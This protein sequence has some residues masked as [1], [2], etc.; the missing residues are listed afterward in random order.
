MK[1]ILII[2][3]VLLLSFALVMMNNNRPKVIIGRLVKK[4]AGG[5]RLRYAVNLVG[6][7]PVGEAVFF[8]ERVEPYGAGEE[9]A[10]HLSAKAE[11]LKIYS[12]LVRGSALLDSYLDKTTLDPLL[13]RQRLL[14]S[15]EKEAQK[16]VFYDQGNRIMSIEGERR[17]I[18]S[19]T[20]DPLSALFNIRRMD[21][22][23]TKEFEMNINTN[24]KNYLLKAVA[25]IEELSIKNKKY[26]IVVIDADIS[27]RQKSPY[28]K[29]TMRLVLWKDRQNL[30]VYI[31]VFASGFLI[32]CRLIDIE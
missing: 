27:R 6:V 3:V 23:K 4:S 24:Q 21:F 1:K 2:L 22:D 12:R 11:S 9:E 26:R 10:Y 20:Q 16:E 15:G 18:L 25:R 17:E 31:K 32:S 14:F 8:K 7:I 30:P 19:H 28:H 29:T 5:E 13:F